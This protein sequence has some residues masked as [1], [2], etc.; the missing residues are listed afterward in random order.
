MLENAMKY[1]FIPKEVYSQR[2]KSADDGTL[3]M[4]LF[5]DVVRQ[6]RL[7]AGLASVNSATCYDSVTHAIASLVFQAYGV[8]EEAVQS[9]LYTIEEMKYYSRTAYGDSKN[10]IG[11]K[12]SVKFLGLCQG[13]G[14]APAGWAVIII[15]IINAHKKKGHGGQF[16]CLILQRTGNLA[17]ILFVD[18]N[19]LINIEMDQDQTAAEAHEDLQA[20]VNIWGKLLIASGGSLKPFLLVG[21]EYCDSY[22][23]PPSRCIPVPLTQPLKLY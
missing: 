9:M 22:Y 5:E 21:V 17:A 19:D 8:P 1:G 12:I 3:A 16:V 7:T 18:D 15:K 13:D 6:T 4:V 2:G 23:R 11:H 20:S 10:Y 14:A